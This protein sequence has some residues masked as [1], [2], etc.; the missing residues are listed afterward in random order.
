MKIALIENHSGYYWGWTN[1]DIQ[2][3]TWT[4][5]FGDAIKRIQKE[6]DPSEVP[7]DV[8]EGTAHDTTSYLD[9]STF[10][11]YDVSSLSEEWLNDADG[12]DGKAI[13]KIESLKFLGTYH[14]HKSG[15]FYSR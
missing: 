10:H 7:D 8:W 1:I 15:L 11:V 12:Q 14:S 9:R 6:I 2:L 13:E 3:D 5:N 4:D